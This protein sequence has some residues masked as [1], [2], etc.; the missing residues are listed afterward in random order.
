MKL[1]WEPFAWIALGGLIVWGYDQALSTRQA[2][3]GRASVS[4]EKRAANAAAIV[5]AGPTTTVTKTAEGDL[6]E[7]AIPSL[8][9]RSF[10]QIRRCTVWRDAAT[11]TVAMTCAADQDMQLPE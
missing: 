3:E 8:L 2:R 4:S 10:V 6:I 9:A 7:I 1:T 11:R 5:S